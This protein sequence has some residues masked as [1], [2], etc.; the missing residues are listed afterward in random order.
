MRAGLRPQTWVSHCLSSQ[1]LPLGSHRAAGGCATK[2]TD[3]FFP[4]QVGGNPD[5][6]PITLPA[7]A[8]GASP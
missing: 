4:N 2:L 3:V 8:G 7:Q 5:V 6:Q 1:V